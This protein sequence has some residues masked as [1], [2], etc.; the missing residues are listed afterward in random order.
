MTALLLEWLAARGGFVS[1]KK[2]GYHTSTPARTS[3][4]PVRMN[5]EPTKAAEPLGFRFPALVT[6]TPKRRFKANA[7]GKQHQTLGLA[8]HRRRLKRSGRM[9]LSWPMQPVSIVS[10]TSTILTGAPY[11]P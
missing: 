6:L 5:S 2:V 10:S 7:I 8:S 4:S 1:T 11:T 3:E 9:I